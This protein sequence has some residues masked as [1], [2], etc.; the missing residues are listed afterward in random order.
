M[1]EQNQ[2]KIKAADII[3]SMSVYRQTLLQLALGSQSKTKNSLLPL[4]D[5]A[6]L[7]NAPGQTCCVLVKAIVREQLKWELCGAAK[8]YRICRGHTY[9][10][11]KG[12]LGGHLATSLGVR[13]KGWHAMQWH[14]DR[15]HVPLSAHAGRTTKRCVGHCTTM[16]AT[17]SRIVATGQCSPE[18]QVRFHD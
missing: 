4:S 2:S 11:L 9:T 10:S 13:K 7:Q 1:Q 5:L 8:C 17:A 6:K 16:L 15:K 14:K 18:R 12:W 3:T